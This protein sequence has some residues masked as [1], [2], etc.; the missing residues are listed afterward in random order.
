M[1][2]HVTHNGDG[3]DTLVGMARAE[4]HDGTVGDLWM[5]IE[6]DL[7]GLTYAEIQAAAPCCIEYDGESALIV[8]DVGSEH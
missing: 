1:R 4:G 6:G 8:Q 3:S 5:P 2:L 7:W